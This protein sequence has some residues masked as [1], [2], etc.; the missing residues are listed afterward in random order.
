MISRTTVRKFL[1]NA[2]IRSGLETMALAD[3]GGLLRGAGGRA[4]IFT[5]H[6]VHPEGDDR[7]SPN[8]LLSITP[9]FLE[10]AIQACLER[11]MT[12]LALQDL[13]E[14]MADPRD[15][16]K[17]FCVT[18][19]DGYRDNAQ[20]AAPVFRRYNIPYTIFITAG[21][22][23]RTRSI[24]WET[25]EALLA[26]RSAFTFDFGPGEERLAAETTLQKHAVFDRFGAYVARANEDQAVARIDALARDCGLDPLGLVDRLTMDAKALRDLQQSD[27]L[28]RLGAHT[29]THVNLKRVDE[30]R[31]EKELKGS[32]DAVERYAGYRPTALAYPYGYASAV[33]ERE[34]AAARDAGFSIAVTT[35]PGLVNPDSFLQPTSLCRVSLN[36]LYQRKRYVRALISGVPFKLMRAA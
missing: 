10:R 31:L 34:F 4:A 22:V 16:R 1:R 36:G 30:D 21:F 18:L 9:R 7:G 27:P 23:E 11:G 24:W 2:L 33:G 8:A 19:D 15:D 28:L 20:F 6:H 29:L 32:A 25:L 17:Y 12:P 35:R 13:P 14:R 26:R 3:A 5:L